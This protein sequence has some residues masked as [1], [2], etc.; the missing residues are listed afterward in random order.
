M[1]GRDT[2]G[3]ISK[4]FLPF[5]PHVKRF[6]SENSGFCSQLM[7]NF[8]AVEKSAKKPAEPHLRGPKSALRR[9]RKYTRPPPPS[10]PFSRPARRLLALSATAGA[11]QPRVRPRSLAVRRGRPADHR[12]RRPAPASHARRA[13][14]SSLNI[15]SFAEKRCRR[16][17][18]PKV[19]SSVRNSGST[20]T[21]STLYDLDASVPSTP[22]IIAAPPRTL[23]APATPLFPPPNQK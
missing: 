6:T 12:T 4:H 17:T 13:Y 11:P 18:R 9:V 21:D 8:S 3:P 20:S 15:Y 1:G 7:R 10:S 5:Q 19:S 2:L 22:P 16:E 23:P 14:R